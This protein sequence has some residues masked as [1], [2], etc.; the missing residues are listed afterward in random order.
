M[1]L[2]QMA[3]ILYENEKTGLELTR[4]ELLL[5]KLLRE[6]IFFG[7]GA[8]G[9][10]TCFHVAKKLCGLVIIRFFSLMNKLIVH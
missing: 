1:F 6:L 2:I 10:W 8:V 9:A 7:S 4:V 5:F 3:A